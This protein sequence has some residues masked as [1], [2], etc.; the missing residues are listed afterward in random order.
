MK[1]E[2]ENNL[3]ERKSKT[4]ICVKHR[5]NA[6]N[7]YLIDVITVVIGSMAYVYLAFC[8]LCEQGRSIGKKTVIGTISHIRRNIFIENHIFHRASCLMRV[9]SHGSMSYSS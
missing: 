6:I 9:S 2:E 7:C 3:S 1:R 4:E 8:S 5:H